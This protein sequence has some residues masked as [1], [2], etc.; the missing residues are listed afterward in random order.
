M[1]ICSPY[2]IYNEFNEQFQLCISELNSKQYRVWFIAILSLFLFFPLLIMLVLYPL[3]IIKLK[4]QRVPG[5][6]INFQ[7]VIRRKRQ[8]YRMTM[9]FIVITVA[10][11]LCW[12]PY[13]IRLL[14]VNV[15][16]HNLD[17][18]IFIYFSFIAI[19]TP[20]VFHAINP[21]IYFIFLSSF[22]QGFK[23]IFRSS[24]CSRTRPQAPA[25]NFELNNIPQGLHNN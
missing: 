11:L 22:R 7:A 18:C 16:E 13:I 21:V 25:D 4:Q 1:A 8:N 5:N 10:F 24:C 17:S 6:V 20:Y 2:L 15:I 9:M 19:I 12:G 3:I 14:L 23:N